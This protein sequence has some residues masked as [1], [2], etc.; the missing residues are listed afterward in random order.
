M[1]S[2]LS[3]DKAYKQLKFVNTKHRRR[4]F[5]NQQ[6]MVINVNVNKTSVIFQFHPK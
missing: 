1:K 4:L 2:K 3:T 6:A 5:S